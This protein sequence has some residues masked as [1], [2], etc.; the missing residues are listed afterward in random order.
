VSQKHA[1][2]IIN[3]GTASAA[4]LEAVIRHVQ[5]TVA[6]VHGIELHPEVRIVGVP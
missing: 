5:R 3:H 1:N 2:F 6:H 4:D